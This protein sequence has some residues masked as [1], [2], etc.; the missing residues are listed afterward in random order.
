VA[1]YP[2]PEY[3]IA[4]GDLY[5]IAG[6]PSDAATQYATVRVEERLFAAAGVDTDL[7]VALFD[8]DHGSPTRAVAEATAEWGRRHGILVADALAWSLFKAGRAE[9]AMPYVELARRLGYRSALIA[10]HAGMT[11]RATGDPAAARRD[12]RAAIHTNPHFSILYAEVAREAL[13]G[14]E[15][16]AGR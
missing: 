5:S 12:L 10:F 15:G 16:G 3:V 14:L 4:L 2:S 11:E 13:A 7:E 9:E 1:R 8:A 6:R